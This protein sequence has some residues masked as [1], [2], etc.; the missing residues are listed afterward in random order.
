[1]GCDGDG[2][3]EGVLKSEVGDEGIGV[4]GGVKVVPVEECVG[5]AA[6]G[7]DTGGD[8]V[9]EAEG[10]WVG[11]D[12]VEEIVDV[13]SDD[14]D[15][16]AVEIGDVDCPLLIEGLSGEIGCGGDGGVAAEG[17]SLAEAGQVEPEEVLPAIGGELLDLTGDVVRG[18]Y[19]ILRGED[20]I[21]TAPEGVEGGGG[22][23]ARVGEEKGV[24]LILHVGG[25]CAAG[26]GAAYGVVRSAG[27]GGGRV[28]DADFG[29]ELVDPEAGR[30]T[31]GWRVG[32]VA[33]GEGDTGDVSGGVA[34]RGNGAEGGDGGVAGV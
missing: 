16:D 3:A 14:V 2:A 7:R 27:E 24:H 34:G 23:V 12:L 26:A 19:W 1:L 10:G 33:D 8:D 5:I 18:G 29:G 28:G 20:V 30:A 4:G 21:G 6:G 13:H 25:T 22:G 11:E 15:A 9:V 17:W 31:A 32:E